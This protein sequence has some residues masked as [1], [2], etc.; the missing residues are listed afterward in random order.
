MRN[1]ERIIPLCERLAEAWEKLP[2][3]RL[4]QLLV[5]SLGGKD[6]FYIEDE[7][8]I[9]MLERFVRENTDSRQERSERTGVM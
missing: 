3:L 4:G 2:D 5:D 6:P 7:D 8:L 9:R 1:P